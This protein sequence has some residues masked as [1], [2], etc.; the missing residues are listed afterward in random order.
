MKA[1]PHYEAYHEAR[2]RYSLR[3]RWA[4]FRHRA[5]FTWADWRDD[6]HYLLRG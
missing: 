1:A 6:L 3:R 5:R 2:P 4:W